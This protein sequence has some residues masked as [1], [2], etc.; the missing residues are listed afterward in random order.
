MG[1]TNTV[2]Q[3]E[4]PLPG[5][6]VQGTGLPS[7]CLDLGA[8]GYLEDTSNAIQVVLCIHEQR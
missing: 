3:N 8:K 2:F 5:E 4:R 7:L 1:I 6:D